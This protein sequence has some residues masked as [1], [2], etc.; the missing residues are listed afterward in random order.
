M[1]EK[2][3]RP[4][5]DELSANDHLTLASEALSN[6]ASARDTP[7]GER[8]MQRTV[9]A[10]NAIYDTELTETQGWQFMVL[11]KAVRG[12][13]GSFLAD[14][15][16]D[17]VGYAALAG[18][19]AAGEASAAAFAERVTSALRDQ[20]ALRRASPPVDPS[21]NADTADAAALAMQPPGRD[22]AEGLRNFADKMRMSDSREKG[23]QLQATASQM[24][25][26]E[27]DMFARY[28]EHLLPPADLWSKPRCEAAFSAW[29]KAVQNLA[30][31]E[32]ALQ[33]HRA[34]FVLLAKLNSESPAREK[35]PLP[36][37][38]TGSSPGR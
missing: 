32:R 13:Q 31:A 8:S 16:V 26:T 37:S 30:D 25:A 35:K 9:D 10:F 5:N 2:N 15:Y 23:L 34:K 29:R 19:S 11:L 7:D 1:S 18:E 28:R 33:E 3:S 21:P 17:Q 27:R 22:P 38:E 14:D 6:R 20:V 24:A 36:S 4:E 12:S